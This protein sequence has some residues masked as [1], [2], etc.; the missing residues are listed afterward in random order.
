MDIA[1]G[2]K[3]YNL[4]PPILQESPVR[5]RGREPQ[6]L[7]VIVNGGVNPFDA[8]PDINRLD[9]FEQMPDPGVPFRIIG[10]EDCPGLALFVGSPDVLDI[11]YGQQEALL[12]REAQTPSGLD[13][14]GLLLGYV[15]AYG[16][17][18][19]CAVREAHLLEHGVVIRS[20]EE[21]LEGKKGAIH[22]QLKVTELSLVQGYRGIAERRLFYV[23]DSSEMDEEAFGE[24]FSHDRIR[25]KAPPLSVPGRNE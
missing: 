3:G 24:K 8:A 21:A 1:L 14:F 18:P 19:E 2:L 6:V 23:L 7:E 25:G 10:P 9:V 15:E 4:A 22:Q 16:N 17:R 12:I 5:L 13:S 20:G 11:E